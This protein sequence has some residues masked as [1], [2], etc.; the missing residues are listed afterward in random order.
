LQVLRNRALGL[1]GEQEPTV[2]NNEGIRKLESM[3]Q[4]ATAV[5]GSIADLHAE[6]TSCDWTSR[7]LEGMRY[8]LKRMLALLLDYLMTSSTSKRFWVHSFSI[9]PALDTR[10]FESF[11]CPTGQFFILIL[12]YSGL[13]A[14]DA[15]NHEAKTFSTTVKGRTLHLSGSH[16]SWMASSVA[17]PSPNAI[18]RTTCTRHQKSS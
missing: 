14:S 3:L 5:Y 4:M 13:S 17:R 8:Q 16:R 9:S 1:K 2:N 11:T 12:M 6:S 7:F 18:I 15:K 10:S